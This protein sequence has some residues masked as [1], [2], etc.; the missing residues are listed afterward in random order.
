V[1]PV[2]E[3]RRAFAEHAEALANQYARSKSSGYALEQYGRWAIERIR[4]RV[5]VRERDLHALAHAVAR[6]TGGEPMAILKILV[7]VQSAGQIQGAPEEH[8]RTMQALSRILRDV[9]GASS[10]GKSR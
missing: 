6:R 9:G 5:P 1:E 10:E 3:Q 2:R 7:E 4:E 8:H